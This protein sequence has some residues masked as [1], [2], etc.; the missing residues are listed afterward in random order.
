[1]TSYLSSLL[2]RSARR[3][4]L[5][6]LLNLDDHLL[7]DIGVTRADLH[8]M[9]SGSRTAHPARVRTHE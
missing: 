4:T 5:A 2:R 7:R 1:M 3:K 6:E 9:M 8:L